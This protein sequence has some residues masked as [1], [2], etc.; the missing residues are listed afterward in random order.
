M[1][2]TKVILSGVTNLSD[3]RYAAGMGVDYIGF[4][5]N[6]DA[7]GYV[8]PEEVKSITKWLSGVSIIG[9]LGACSESNLNDYEIDLI[10]FS[11]LNLVDH[12]DKSILSLTVD[13]K[14]I[15]MVSQVLGGVSSQVSFFI[16]AVARENIHDLKSELARYC[17]KYPI[18]IS[19][20]MDSA[21]LSLVVDK[22]NPQGIVLFGNDEV[23]PGLSSYDGIADVLE[24]LEVE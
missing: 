24:K 15:G 8:T 11:D 13:K 19:T 4:T 9:D 5:V 12:F 18:Y 23:K 20:E 2:K 17:S 14:N 6:P 3:A 1:L 10:Q 16:L 21:Y 22:I 7:K